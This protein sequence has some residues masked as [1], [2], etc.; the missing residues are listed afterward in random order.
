MSDSVFAV[1]L[2]VTEIAFSLAV[3]KML[4]KAG[5]SKP[6]L[7]STSVFLTAWLGGMYYLLDNKLF[8]ASGIP[9]IAFALGVATPIITGYAA[10]TLWSPLRKAIHKIPTEGF[11]TLQ[12]WRAVFGVLF[13][14]TAALPV[15]FQ[16]IGGL[17]D[18]TAGISAFIALT[19][20][21]K[22][23]ISERAAII[24]GNTLGILDFIIV[25]NLGLFVVLKDQS[26]DIMFD[27]IP[28]YVVPL[29]ILLHIFSLQRLAGH[30]ENSVNDH[31]SK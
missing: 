29:F 19:V 17:G 13:F 6:A 7:I 2:V 22:K 4:F 25:L 9:Q 5:M 31:S 1:V 14:F 24:G 27:L 10:S 16:L 12:I 3:L 11:L 21:K 28:L 18:I 20:F 23:R 30:S 26:P 15:W 8:S